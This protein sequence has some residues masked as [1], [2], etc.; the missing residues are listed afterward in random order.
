MTHGL[1]GEA[2][3]VVAERGRLRGLQV[4]G[5][6]PERGRLPGGL[7][8]DRAG[9]RGHVGVQAG[10]PVPEGE[11]ERDA[12]RLAAGPPQVQAAGGRARLEVANQGPALPDEMQGSLFDSM[13]SIRAGREAEPHLGLGLYIVRLIAEFHGGTVLAANRTDI[14]GARFTVLLALGAG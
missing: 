6:G 2:T 13:V 14:E 11:A 7:V 8:R 10:Q 5:V 3:Q 1:L 4:R 12:A 9:E